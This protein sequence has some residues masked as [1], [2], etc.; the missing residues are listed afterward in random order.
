[1]KTIKQFTAVLFSVFT[2]F[3]SCKQQSEWESLFNGKDLSGWT[4]ICQ[5]QDVEKKFWTVENGA[6]YCNSMHTKDHNYVWLVS[7]REFGDFELHLKFQAYTDSPGNS[8][9]Q[10]RSRYDSAIDGG[11]MHG[12]QVD[13]NPPKSMPWRTGL[14]YDETFEEKRWIYPSLHNWDMPPEYEPKEHVLKYAEEDDSWNELILICKGMHIKTIVN[15]IVRTDWDAS[16]VL[17]NEHHKKHNVGAKGHFAFQL[18]SG[19]M[20]KIKYKDIRIKEFNH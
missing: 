8:G 15:G 4:V 14:I 5:P 3:V 12:P 7:D 10:F 20:L 13:I 19:D 9:I 11:W 6:I 18:H 2:L 16:G 17:D 1:M